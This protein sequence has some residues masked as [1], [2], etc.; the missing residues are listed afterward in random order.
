[1]LDHVSKDFQKTVAGQRIHVARGYVGG[2]QHFGRLAASTPLVLDKVT[3]A[4]C[5]R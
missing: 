4:H 1:M 2:I 5:L 3:A